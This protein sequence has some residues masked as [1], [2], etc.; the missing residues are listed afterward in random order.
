MRY[1]HH[2]KLRHGGGRLLSLRRMCFK[3]IVLEE[4]S[5]VGQICAIYL[6]TAAQRSECSVSWDSIIK[7][8]KLITEIAV[9]C[10]T[11]ITQFLEVAYCGLMHVRVVLGWRGSTAV[12]LVNE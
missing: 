3:E 6:N 5:T 2:E 1:R 9:L 8:A 12:T 11:F 7:I 4:M 10:F